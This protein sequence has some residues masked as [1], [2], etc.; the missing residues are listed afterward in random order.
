[1]MNSN[2]LLITNAEIYGQL[3]ASASTL[4]NVRCANGLIENIGGQLKP[5]ADEVIVDAKGGALLPGLHDHHI[6]LMSLAAA[7]ASV[8]CGPP[9]V[10]N[11]QQLTQTLQTA[12]VSNDWL[13]G[14]AYHDAVAGELDRTLLD[15][16]IKERPVRIQHRS[17]KMWIVNSAAAELLELDKEHHQPG[18]ER[19]STGKA[20]GRLF[21]MDDWLRQKIGN[22]SYPDLT[23][24]SLLLAS[25][26]VTGITDT[27]PSNADSALT[28]FTKAVEESRLLQ[29][30]LMM[31]DNTLPMPT[32]P[33]LQRGSVKLLLDEYQLP[34]FEVFK[35]AIQ[36][37]HAQQRSVAIHCVTQTESIFALTALYEAG[38][39]LGDR[40]E[41]ASIFP[42][43]ILPL[44][45]QTGVTVVTQ[46][47]FIY[48]RGDQ[49]LQ[50]VDAKDQPFL[51]RLQGFLT[52][53]IPLAGSSDAPYGKPDPWIAIKAAVNR[54]T[55]AGH[56]IAGNEKLTPEQALALFISPADCPGG[57]IKKIAI[58]ENADLCLLKHNWQTT[59]YRLCSEDVAVTII[60]GLPVFQID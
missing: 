46:P 21:R 25:Y 49:Y 40:I 23:A 3:P 34:D 10:N 41:H 13:R 26:G 50:D 35:T 56:I 20:T 24:V 47:G 52:H 31:G 36:Q 55:I 39:M 9:Q 5:R 8:I 59:R 32:H 19:D 60:N 18:I 58:G 27:T 37:A 33:M 17:G 12:E 7:N 43:D 53:N 28:E 38:V 11:L 48:E 57:A 30:V 45:Q 14:I 22:Q 29:R 15:S 42:N 44:L 6:H 2:S 51:Y 4:T 54:S 16:I 1:M